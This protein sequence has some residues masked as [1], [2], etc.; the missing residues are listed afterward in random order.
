MLRCEPPNVSLVDGAALIER[1][2]AL[3]ALFDVETRVMRRRGG[4]GALPLRPAEAAIV[5]RAVE[6][7]RAEFATGRACAHA[8]LDAWGAPDAPLL[9]GPDRAPLWPDGFVGSISHARG[10]CAAVA[11]PRAVA[12]AWASTWSPSACWR[13]V[14]VRWC[15]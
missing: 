14:C 5:A 9:P 11:A 1:A 10:A 7:R 15:A 4:G 2:V 8:A 13:G 3:E 12:A 6:K